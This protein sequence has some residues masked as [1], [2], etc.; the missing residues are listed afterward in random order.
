MSE[1]WRQRAIKMNFKKAVISFVITG[2]A[3]A[4]GVS[5]VLYSNFR[6]RI[7]QWEQRL[8]TDRGH[9]EKEREADEEHFSDS[10]DREYDGNFREREENDWENIVKSLHLSTGDLVLIAG[11]GIIGVV[12]VVWY[13]VL[14]MIAV[15]RKSCRMDVNASLWVPAALI[16]NLA[17]LAALYLYAM[18]KGTCTN[19]G[20][21][22]KG[23]GK[24]CS[25]C[26]NLLK[27]ECPQCRQIEDLSSVFCS[28]C[29]KKL[30]EKE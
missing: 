15:Y 21:I 25:R 18:L 28:N 12:M 19:C 27:K 23:S 22:K 3:A 9:E 14:V 6:G 7:P 26:G 16:F 10:V 13:W 17:A 11:C 30:D 4:I 5:A 2:L 24:F 8:E 20:R 29:G 1:K